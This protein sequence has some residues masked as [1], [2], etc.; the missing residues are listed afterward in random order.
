MLR[1]EWLSKARDALAFAR[2][3]FA[4]SGIPGF[5]C[6]M[7]HQAAE[8]ALKGHLAG[9][10]KAPP[11]IHSLVRLLDFCHQVDPRYAASEQDALVLDPW[12]IPGRYPV[13]RTLEATSADAEA[14]LEAAAR[15]LDAS[16]PTREPQEG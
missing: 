16:E 12:Y 1:D 2:S 3:G 15:I 5:T 9:L 7:A 4:G 14:A 10:G 8:L 13:Q 11:R 6:F